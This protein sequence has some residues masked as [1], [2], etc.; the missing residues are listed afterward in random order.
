MP[1]IELQDFN[2]DS[3]IDIAFFTPDG[4]ATILYNQYT[5]QG[6]TAT[7]LCNDKT[8]TS[9][10]KS[11]PMFS[12]YPFTMGP[13][14]LQQAMPTPSSSL[15]FIGISDSASGFTTTQGTVVK[16]VPGR[17]RMAD[18]DQDSYVDIVA[19]VTYYNSTSA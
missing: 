6:P 15:S 8:P 4:T 10:L 19:T 2:R 1:L 13:N 11:S 12:S 5:A 14:V 9:Y 7:N 18:L 17:L 16:P 3:M